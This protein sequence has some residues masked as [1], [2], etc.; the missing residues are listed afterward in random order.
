FLVVL[1]NALLVDL[2]FSLGRGERKK[3]IV[4]HAFLVFFLIM[5]CLVWGSYKLHLVSFSVPKEKLS[6]ALIQPNIDQMEKMDP[7]KVLSIYEIHEQMSRQAAADIIVWP[8]T[9]IFTYLLRDN[10]YLSRVRKLAMDSQ[11]WLIIGTPHYEDNKIYNSLVVIS[12]SGEVGSRYDKEHLVPFGEYLPFRGILYPWL[13]AVGYYDQEFSP[14]PNPKLLTV[15]KVK[16]APAICFESTFPGLVK[17]RVKMGADFILTVTNDAWFGDSPAPYFH[18]NC[19]VFR[20]LENRKY[21][22]QVGNNGISAVI[23]PWGRIMKKSELN[24]R[25]ILTFEIP[26]T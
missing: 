8:E 14:N 11:A 5:A 26:L 18:L 4:F 7:R 20:A 3:I 9:A 23:D 10:F 6:V 13:R 1:I 2:G 22:V 24:Q 15:K 21:F 17:K 16:I 25:T 12:P 19:G